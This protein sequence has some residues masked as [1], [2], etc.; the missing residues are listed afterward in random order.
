MSKNTTKDCP[1]DFGHD[2]T[3]S[4]KSHY[5]NYCKRKSIIQMSAHC[6]GH[7]GSTV[8]VRILIEH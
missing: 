8:G 4:Q 1:A 6:S 2:F 7:E 5:K 3:V